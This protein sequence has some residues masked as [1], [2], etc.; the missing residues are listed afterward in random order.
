MDKFAKDGEYL[1]VFLP[2]TSEALVF[3]VRSIVNKAFNLIDY[4]PLPIS[5]GTVL[6]TIDGSST[7]APDYGVL[8]ARAYTDPIQFPSQLNVYDNTDMWYIPKEYRD[9]LFHVIQYVKPAWLRV[10]VQIPTG[11]V[12]N[13][14][15]KERVMGGVEK[16]F[17]FTRG[18]IEVIHF[19]EVHYGFRYCND[20]NIDVNT[21]V[22]FEYAEYK[23][24]IP[25]DAQLIFDILIRKVPSVWVSLP[26]SVEDST[27]QSSL[28]KTYGITG[29]PLHGINE[30]DA[31]IREYQSL[32]QDVKSVWGGSA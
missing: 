20:L 13:R 18:S 3:R 11:T 28:V 8:P 10:E 14:F 26:Y 21:F 25:M 7:T 24:E 6:K 31:A 23:I 2:A 22:R 9:R 16:D 32:L 30:R 1:T 4:G 15:Q 19:P 5:Q 27:F 17:G 12:Q 29:F